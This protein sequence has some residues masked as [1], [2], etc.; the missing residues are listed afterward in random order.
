MNQYL[1]QLDHPQVA[2]GVKQKR[3]QKIDEAVSAT[4]EM[5][6]YV[7]PK[8]AHVV[9]SVQGEV[10]TIA[11]VGVTKRLA[12]VVEKL[13]ERLEKLEKL[14][15]EHAQPG[16]YSEQNNRTGAGKQPPKGYGGQ[17]SAEG[18]R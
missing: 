18:R 8:M 13:A 11:A 4:L 2:F 3:P 1:Q 5:E 10:D 14:G 16:G 15:S 12:L 7:T 9:S 17:P 6:T